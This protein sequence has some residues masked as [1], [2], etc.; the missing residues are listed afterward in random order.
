MGQTYARSFLRSHVVRYND[1][2]IMERS[3]IKAEQLNHLDLGNVYTQPE[4]CVHEA[5]IVILAVK[6]QDCKALFNKLRERYG[7]KD[8]LILSIM[9]GVRMDTIAKALGT[10]RIVR[11][12]PNLP[13]QNGRGMTVYTGSVSISRKDLTFVTNLIN[14]TGK[15]IYTDQERMIDAATAISGSG[16][17]YVFYFLRALSKA[18]VELGFS[19][20]EAD[21][22]A[23]QTF[24]GAVE[25]YDRS[26]MDAD[27]WISRVSSKGGTTEAA[28]A[29]FDRLDVHDDVL[30][31]VQAAMHRAIELGQED[32]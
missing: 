4:D 14:T 3:E 32:S 13:A 5:D 27:H 18:A 16:P 25:T 1:L 17:A 21:L 9:A 6:P 10:N 23:V 19:E 15:S 28:I 30:K 24:R 31:G 2:M 20:A 29:T 11:A 8:K 26:E 22:M 12:M 7:I